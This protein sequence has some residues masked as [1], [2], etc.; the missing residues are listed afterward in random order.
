ML[1]G[2][3][4]DHYSWTWA[5]LIN[6]PL[7]LVVLCD[8]VAAACRKAAAQR[9]GGGLDVRGAVL[10]TLALGGI[11]YALH[12]SA[13][14]QG[15]TSPRRCSRALACG[16]ARRS[17]F[18]VVERAQRARRCCRCRSFASATSPAPTC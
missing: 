8:R 3:L 14:T 9:R 12:R 5:F 1:G 4:V 10:A 15:W 7:A 11:V 17:L 18:V 13:G 16:I 6:V 2:F